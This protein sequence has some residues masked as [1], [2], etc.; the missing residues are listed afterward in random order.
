MFD[1]YRA[2]RRTGAL[3]IGL[4]CL[5]HVPPGAAKSE[6]EHEHVGAAAGMQLDA[7]HKWA[8]D[9]SLRSGMADIRAAFDANHPA[10]HEGKESDAQ[11]DA[12]AS[13]IEAHVNLIVATCRLPPAADANLH[14]VIADL[15][16]GVNLMW[17]QD[18]TRA[19][20]DGASLVHGALIAYGKYFDDPDWSSNSSADN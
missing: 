14:Y 8:T 1:P 4:L 3:A 16:Q 12:L 6:H 10:I 11:Y 18:P 20:L 13:R 19:R 17:G 15:L 2:V 5:A 9:A 7:S